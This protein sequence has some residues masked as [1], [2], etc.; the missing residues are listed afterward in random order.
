MSNAVCHQ[1]AISLELGDSILVAAIVVVAIMS[2]QA[3]HTYPDWEQNADSSWERW[4]CTL[5]S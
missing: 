3:A 1:G 4:L 2:P 5:L